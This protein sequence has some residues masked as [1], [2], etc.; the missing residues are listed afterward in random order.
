M[1]KT[2]TSYLIVLLTI[3]TSFIAFFF[4]VIIYISFRRNRGY[5]RNVT[6]LELQFSQTLL[7]SQIE[8]QE[9][10][11]RH[12]AR[13]LHDNL[14][15]SASLIKIYLTTLKLEDTDKASAKIEDTKELTR[16][17]IADIKSL[18]VSMGSDRLA[19]VCRR[20]SLHIVI[21]PTL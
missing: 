4:L 15:H 11:L 17:L 12:I 18:S 19:Q 1:E 16:K 3:I 7:Q 20:K 10:T 13:E 8:I 5:H 14:G 6:L 2:E 9:Q 21:K